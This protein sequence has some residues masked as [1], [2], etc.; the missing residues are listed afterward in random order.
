MRLQA[1]PI[2]KQR[3]TQPPVA[4]KAD[5]MIAMTVI[6]AIKAAAVVAVVATQNDVAE[7]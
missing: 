2:S 6:A 1:R 7:N 4:A 3:R 5:A